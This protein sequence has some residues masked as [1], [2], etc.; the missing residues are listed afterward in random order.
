MV[1]QCSFLIITACQLNT[2]LLYLWECLLFTNW[3]GIFVELVII[4]KEAQEKKMD[5]IIIV[6]LAFKNLKD[7][8][9]ILPVCTYTLWWCSSPAKDCSQNPLQRLHAWSSSWK[10]TWLRC[11]KAQSATN[12]ILYFNYIAVS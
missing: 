11:E 8:W 12:D 5:I 6:F 4:Y 9:L 1:A 10:H 7:R 2:S 3:G